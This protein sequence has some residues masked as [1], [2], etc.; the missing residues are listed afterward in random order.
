M[1]KLF[2]EL[3]AVK[4]S[5][6]KGVPVDECALFSATSLLKSFSSSVQS[7]LWQS[8][9]FQ[10][11]HHNGLPLIPAISVSNMVK[12]FSGSLDQCTVYFDPTLMDE[13]AL[14]MLADF[15][16]RIIDST[17]LWYLLTAFTSDTKEPTQAPQVDFLRETCSHAHK[18]VIRLM[19]LMD[20]ANRGQFLTHIVFRM[21]A[22][23]L[24]F[25]SLSKASNTRSPNDL[26]HEFHAMVS[27]L[28]LISHLTPD[29]V[30]EHRIPL[31]AA[32]KRWRDN[33]PSNLK[34]IFTSQKYSLHWARSAPHLFL[35]LL[36][37][38]DSTNEEWEVVF[39]DETTFLLSLQPK[40]DLRTLL[41]KEV[42]RR[43]LSSNIDEQVSMQ[44]TIA[45]VLLHQPPDMDDVLLEVEHAVVNCIFQRWTNGDKLRDNRN[46]DARDSLRH[47]HKIVTVAPAST[48]AVA[49]AAADLA[50]LMTGNGP[51]RA[52][53][54][55]VFFEDFETSCF[56]LLLCYARRCQRTGIDSFQWMEH[57]QS[58]NG[59]SD[60]EGK[61]SDDLEG[62]FE[63]SCFLFKF[64]FCSALHSLFLSKA[65]DVN[66]SHSHLS[67]ATR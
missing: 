11:I 22:S 56:L 51:P 40:Y 35:P 42:E 47:L 17:L 46:T 55:F 63:Y 19:R 37:H 53:T 64:F 29:E 48:P 60:A 39:Q 16:I 12:Y 58:S 9:T 43:L 52:M 32:M 3:C 38:I 25:S 30:Q 54:T 20:E 41:L 50:M 5:V 28:Q 36:I 18:I 21:Q 67:K 13:R 2:I 15:M 23:G 31:L 66:R 57:L 45:K 8:F 65:H 24:G 1:S 6:S 27:L 14:N 4:M 26:Q 61:T 49:T 59:P 7:I 44:R 33:L 10:A 34:D 62:N